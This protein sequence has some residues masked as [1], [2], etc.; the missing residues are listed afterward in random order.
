[1]NSVPV[2]TVGMALL[3]ALKGSS[4]EPRIEHVRTLDSGIFPLIADASARY[5]SAQRDRSKRLEVIFELQAVTDE[6]LALIERIHAEA[7]AR[8]SIIEEL[9]TALNER[10]ARI[11]ALERALEWR[12]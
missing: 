12:S 8:L 3:G 10:D 1:M 9:T 11:A 2:E 5:R 7:A 6:R 4:E